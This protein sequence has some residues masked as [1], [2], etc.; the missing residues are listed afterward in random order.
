MNLNDLSGKGLV[1]GRGRASHRLSRFIE[2]DTSNYYLLSGSFS[3]YRGSGY[4]LCDDTNL[5]LPRLDLRCDRDLPAATAYANEY[6]EMSKDLPVVS[7]SDLGYSSDGIRP[8]ILETTFA[9]NL[10]HFMTDVMGKMAV[11]AEF[12]PISKSIFL[13]Y[14]WQSFHREAFDCAGLSYRVIDWANVYTGDCIIPS[15]AGRATFMPR[16]TVNFLRNLYSH[17]PAHG[18][19]GI[20]YISRNNSKTRR[21]TNED[22]LLANLS[23][24]GVPI[25]KV[26]L[27]D[28]SFPEKIALFKG[29]KLIVAPHGS[30][31]SFLPFVTEGYGVLEIFGS[32][33]Q[34]RHYE[35]M[36]YQCFL[37][38]RSVGADDSLLNLGKMPDGWEKDYSCIPNQII[39]KARELLQL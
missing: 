30:E 10:F 19:S 12:M 28:Y 2:D 7:F 17:I 21:M 1:L 23:V 8:I 36:A 14:A 32:Y 34:S 20:L 5:I 6:S 33:L 18:H 4:V 11:A 35:S 9:G 3:S 13:L 38:Y 27:E 37:N 31:L 26:Y 25:L 22:D 24:L 16:F 29:S 39:D 15:L